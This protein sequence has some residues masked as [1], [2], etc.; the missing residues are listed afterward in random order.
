MQ[1]L[2]ANPSSTRTDGAHSS[3]IKT[4]R[5]DSATLMR[6]PQS[7]VF[8]FLYL[9]VCLSTWWP[10]VATPP[11]PQAYA[12]AIGAILGYMDGVSIYRDLCKQQF[13]EVTER[14][15]K[16]YIQWRTKY[17]AVYDEVTRRRL[18]G[19]RIEAHGSQDRYNKLVRSYDENMTR[20]REGV[21]QELTS[22]PTLARTTCRGVLVILEAGLLGANNALAKQL[23]LIRSVPENGL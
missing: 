15:D 3:W 16:A 4:G 8:G 5:P 22:D 23:A 19:Y 1:D 12:Q 11:T 9:A 17:A 13:P 14:M 6:K 21:R 20:G 7:D 2:R 18:G 10:A